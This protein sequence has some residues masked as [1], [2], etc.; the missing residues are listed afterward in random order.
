M[1][2]KRII[3]NQQLRFKILRLFQ[4]VPDNVM[5]RLQYKIKMGFWPDFKHPKRF[6]EKLQLYKI[7]YRNPVMH[8]CVDKYEVR[9]YVEGKGLG[10]ILNELYGVYDRPEEIDFDAL[11][12][13]FVMKTTTGGGGQNVIVVTDKSTCNLDEL[14]S[15]L[16]LWEGANNLGALA[17][18]EWAYQDCKPRIIIENYLEDKIGGGN[19]SDYKL[20]FFNGKFRSLWIDKDRYTDHH[21]GFWDEN[22]K[23][24]T[25]V[26]S[27]HDTFKSPPTLPDCMSEMI[28]VGEKLSEDFPY[29]RIDLYDVDGK[30]VFG[31]ITFYPWSGYVKFTPSEFD[32]QLGSY[33]TEYGKSNN[34]Q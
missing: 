33:F 8:Q 12:D 30:I 2:Y 19:L 22:L 27:D 23:F 20:M 17:G 32:V 24:L 15:K 21:R 34:Y 3:K 1:N 7:N 11:P 14:R 18:R 13:K 5:L 16:A 4:W 9:K 31:E 25:E 26:Y 10:H 29:A 28:K 6:T